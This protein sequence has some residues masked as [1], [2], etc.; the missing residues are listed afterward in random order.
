MAFTISTSTVN[1][2]NLSAV[3]D[4]GVITASGAISLSAICVLMSGT[5]A[6]LINDGLIASGNIAV[7]IANNAFVVNTGS[8]IGEFRGL[9]VSMAGTETTTTITNSGE[10]IAYDG[11]GVITFD[12]GLEVINSGFISGTLGGVVFSAGVGLALNVLNNSG[13]V[14]SSG[15]FAVTSTGETFILNT[16][17]IA[18]KIN[19]GSGNDTLDNR[20]GEVGGLIAMGNGNNLFRGGATGEEATAG[21]GQDTMRGGAGD[22][23]LAGSSGNDTLVGGDGDDTL[24]GGDTVDLMNGGRGA[25]VFLFLAVSESDTLQAPDR[26]EGFSKAEDVIDLSALTGTPLAFVGTG[27]LSGGTVASVG[28]AKAGGVLTVSVDTSGDGVADMVFLVTGAT[29]LTAANFL[30]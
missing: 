28:Y 9:S 25:D 17:L 3:E 21:T 2:Q 26:I 19:L 24:L 11:V 15:D 7:S 20:L 12:S 23:L 8:I 1:Q 6:R 13:T 4:L 29:G 10:I 30:L 27:P 18:G 14:A 22:D 16:G 5:G